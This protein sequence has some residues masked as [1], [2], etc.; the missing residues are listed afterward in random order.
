MRRLSQSGSVFFPHDLGLNFFLIV[1]PRFPPAC[2]S[3]ATPFFPEQSLGC[4]CFFSPPLRRNI[5]FGDSPFAPRI[6]PCAVSDNDDYVASA[7][8]L[9]PNSECPR[10]PP[11]FF[12]GWGLLLAANARLAYIYSI[13]V[14]KV[15][16]PLSP[17]PIFY[18]LTCFFPLTYR[19][20]FPLFVRPTLFPAPPCFSLHLCRSHTFLGVLRN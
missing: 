15:S 1:S 20:F 13:F 2:C 3:I 9:G 4:P 16:W 17:L 12:F 8:S 11:L 10:D 6:G 14:Y 7:V 5:P 18:A 19:N